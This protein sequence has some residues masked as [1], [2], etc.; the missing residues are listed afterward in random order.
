M[1]N[2]IQIIF[3]YSFQ[4][5]E[6]NLHKLRI[7]LESRKEI[8][9]EEGDFIKTKEI[10]NKTFLI[11]LYKC[12]IPPVN[13]IIIELLSDR[14]F[15]YMTDSINLLNKSVILCFN[16]SFKTWYRLGCRIFIIYD[17]IIINL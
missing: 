17:S 11:Y 9:V 12:K 4:N 15:T 5:N 1:E 8:E 6:K 2:K 10:G 7:R 13:S 16:I 3:L 14:N